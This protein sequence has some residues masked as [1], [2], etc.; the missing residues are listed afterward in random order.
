MTPTDKPPRTFGLMIAIWLSV[1]WF[2]GVPLANTAFVMS[3]RWR[4]RNINIDTTNSTISGGTITG[5]SNLLLAYWVFQAITFLVVA[6]LAW[7][8]RS[9]RSRYL[10]FAMVLALTVLNIGGTVWGLVGASSA[11]ALDS[12]GNLTSSLLGAQLCFTITI[13]LYVM[14]YINRGPARAFYRGYYFPAPDDAEA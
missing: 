8:W 2:T 9:Q 11:N 5:T 13:P 1:V 6:S 12:S 7:N 10:L 3:L 4:F 14:W